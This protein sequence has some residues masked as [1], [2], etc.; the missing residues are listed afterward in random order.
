MFQV[1]AD[2]HLLHIVKGSEGQSSQHSSQHAKQLL[3]P[4]TAT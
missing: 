3:K 4:T 1:F 2:Q